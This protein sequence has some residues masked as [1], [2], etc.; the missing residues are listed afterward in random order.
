MVSGRVPLGWK[1]ILLLFVL[2]CQTLGCADH[3]QRVYLAGV[4]RGRS[5]GQSDD[6]HEAGALYAD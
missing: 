3:G 4:A 1:P 5:E 6:C 2:S